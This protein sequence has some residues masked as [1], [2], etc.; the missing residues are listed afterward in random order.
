MIQDIQ[1]ENME[2]F[3]M[4][5]IPYDKL[6]GYGLT[7]EMIADLPGKVRRQLLCGR[8]TPLMPI[9]TD[10]GNGEQVKRLA[11]IALARLADG[12]VSVQFS[13][14]NGFNSLEDYSEEMQSL[15]KSGRTLLTDVTDKDG[16]SEKCYVQYDEDVNQ[17]VY[18]TAALIQQNLQVIVYN[19][20]MPTRDMLDLIEGKI[21]EKA[22][23]GQ[24]D[25][26]QVWSVGI[27]LN[28]RTGIRVA[29]GDA[30]VWLS[31]AK[32]R[33]LPKYNFG[34]NGCWIMDD[35]GV[36]AYIEEGD[37]PAEI[38]NEQR[39]RGLQNAA[40]SQQAGMRLS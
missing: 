30:S 2:Q 6:K 18:V 9:I 23:A 35:K 21:V 28:E 25:G 5:E 22:C 16:H 13:P 33:S 7:E 20:Q 19:M 34:V 10:N 39:R 15:L 37:Y 3:T 38:L 27:D 40:R 29:D 36:L 26:P 8:W 1:T 11:K 4:D 31:D 17:V 24:E 12:T 14:Y 32:E